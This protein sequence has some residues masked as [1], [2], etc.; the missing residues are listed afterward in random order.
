MVNRKILEAVDRLSLF[1]EN[2]LD[3]ESLSFRRNILYA[4]RELAFK[5]PDYNGKQSLII[6]MKAEHSISDMIMTTESIL[7]EL[8][9]QFFKIKK[10]GHD[11][12]QGTNFIEFEVNA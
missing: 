12:Y 8:N 2:T 3:L 11:Y 1:Y 6:S 5:P 10:S 9:F 4:I 7:K